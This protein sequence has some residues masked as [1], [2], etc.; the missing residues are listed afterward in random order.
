MSCRRAVEDKR[1]APAQDDN[2]VSTVLVDVSNLK[3]VGMVQDA[4]PHDGDGLQCPGHP[5]STGPVRFDVEE[6]RDALTL[7]VGDDKIESPVA[8]EVDGF[9]GGW[10]TEATAGVIVGTLKV[11]LDRDTKTIAVAQQDDNE[12]TGRAI[13]QVVVD[14]DDKIKLFVAV[15]VRGGDHCLA[16]VPVVRRPP[17]AEVI[18]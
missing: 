7:K 8:V 1:H 9:S 12:I 18:G 17:P 14:R 3:I 15:E 5:K 4:E 10:P 11:E 16:I 13:I 2:I 6:D